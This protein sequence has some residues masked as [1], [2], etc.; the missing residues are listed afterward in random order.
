MNFKHNKKLNILYL[1]FREQMN[2]TQIKSGTVKW[3]QAEFSQI[4][5]HVADGLLG[6]METQFFVAGCRPL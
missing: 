3:P 4:R 2:C 5:Q 6:R 1:N